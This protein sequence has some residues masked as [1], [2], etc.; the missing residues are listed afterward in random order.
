MN[1]GLLLLGRPGCPTWMP[2]ATIVTVLLGWYVSI[3]TILLR[4]HSRSA[5]SRI[6]NKGTPY[7]FE[8]GL[9]EA[10]QHAAEI[11]GMSFV[12]RAADGDVVDSCHLHRVVPGDSLVP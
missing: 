11:V 10:V 7:K 5:S 1:E 8:S 12:G 9:M 3:H 2:L 6:T 4:P